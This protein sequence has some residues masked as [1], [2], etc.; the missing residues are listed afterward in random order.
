MPADSDGIVREETLEVAGKRWKVYAIGGTPAQ[1]VQ[2]GILDIAPRKPDLVVAGIN[3]G[4]NVGSGITISGTVGAALEGASFGIPAMAI[5]LQTETHEHRSY[6]RQID[7][8]AAAH[9]T[10]YFAR[11][12]LRG[13]RF[14]DVDVLKVDVPSHAVPDTPWRVTRV[15]RQK[16]Y[17]PVPP[18]KDRPDRP[19]LVGYRQRHDQSTLE[20]D[21]DAYAV[22]VDQVVAVTP[23]SLDLTSR[24]D[25][26]QFEQ[27]LRR[28]GKG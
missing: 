17:E 14:P 25:L 9:F 27:D 1:A 4:E 3:Y 20:P 19:R 7:F 23:L 6:S 11:I 18:P 13:A 24:I 15:S 16:Y 22:A 5:S 21:S 2:L 10:R 26:R 8:T 12:L 28:L